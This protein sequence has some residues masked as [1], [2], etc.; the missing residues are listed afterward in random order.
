M[1]V[2]RFDRDL[3]I[4]LFWRLCNAED[5][6]LGTHFIKW[7]IFFALQTHFQELAPVL[8]RMVNSEIPE[9][10]IAGARQACLAAL[11]LPEASPLAGLCLSGS[12][13]QRAGAAQVMA[14]NIKVAT[15]RPFCEKALVSLF[16]DSSEIVRD[17]ACEMF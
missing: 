11:D 1:A 3:A 14:A 7:F 9:V 4:S 17:G 13:S 15:C 6:L 2:W 5:A 12:E 16:N 8:E 10:A